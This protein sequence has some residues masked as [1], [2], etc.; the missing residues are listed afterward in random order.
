MK[1]IPAG[2]S[3]LT[4]RLSATYLIETRYPLEAAATAMAGEQSSGTFRA[5]PGET[6]ELLRRFGARVEF[7][8][9]IGEVEGEA[10]PFSRAPK[11]ATSTRPRRAKVGLSWNIENTG[12]VLAS[13]WSTVLGNLFELHHLSAMRLLDVTFP[14]AFADAYP[15]PAF[16]VEGT[17]RLTGVE[18]RPLI[19][20]IVK[21]SV[22]LS[23]EETARLA[24]TLI[25]AGLDFIKD[26][27]LMGDPPHSPFE[28]RFEAVMAVIDR[29][30][31]RTGR[32]VMYAANIS[33]D[34]DP[35]RRQLDLIERRGG[36][37]A[38]LVL[39]SV[40]LSGVVEMRR[41]STV[42]LHGHRA[43][44]GLFSRSPDLGMSYLAYQ[45]FWRLAGIDHMHVNGLSNKFCEPDDS[46][47]ASAHACLTPM[48]G[49]A[50]R[51]DTVMPVLSSGQTAVQAGETYARLGSNDFIYCCG[52]GIMAH[53]GGPA[54]G[55][56][57]LHDAF[58]AAAAGIPAR[59]YAATHPELEAALLTFG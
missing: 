5:I 21:P 45:K 4:G 12:T 26:D 54:A 34:I 10:L 55:V 28:Q 19:G 22:G 3:A 25:S 1:I 59:D 49:R 30:A 7:I 37:C 46:V 17:R 56:R 58:E 33:G 38:M 39:N 8:E 23:P 27:E 9:D 50:D 40:G 44:W 29:H 35:M 6:P 20:T 42:A 57:S 51:P 14:D 15:G 24:D 31:D 48:F 11:N 52:G 2:T 16:A 18:G 32:K 36:T 43:G 41:H 47:M 53:P 13:V